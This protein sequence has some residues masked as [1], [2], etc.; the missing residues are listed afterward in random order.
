[1]KRVKIELLKRKHEHEFETNKGR[2]KYLFLPAKSSDFLLVIFSAFPSINKPASYNYVDTF[3]DVNCHR[4][5]ILDDFGPDIRGGSYYLGKNKDFFIAEMVTEFIEH[6]AKELGIQ[7]KNIITSGTSKGGYAS[8]YFSFKNG[9]GYSIVGAPQTLL[10]NYLSDHLTYFEYIAG[11]FNEAAVEF[12]NEQLFNQ[13][14]NRKDTPQIFL[15]VGKGEH[16]YI[17]HVLPFC[18]FLD[19]QGIPYELD[20]QDYNNHSDVGKF[21]PSFALQQIKEIT[22]T[23]Q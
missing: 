6:K 3:K 10:G 9:Y 5:Y 22:R 21:Y 4:I 12:L 8:L 11:F 20:I 1:M 16:H 15:H 7:Y 17:D 2:L 23:N 19:V 18:N 14:K 13:V